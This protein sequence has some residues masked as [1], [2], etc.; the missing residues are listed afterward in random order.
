MAER[1]SNNWMRDAPRTDRTSD[2]YG[3]QPLS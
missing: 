3:K 2:L 1:M